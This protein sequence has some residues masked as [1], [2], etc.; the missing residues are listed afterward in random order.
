MRNLMTILPKRSGR[1]A[2]GSITVRHQGGR[3]KRFLREIDFARNKREV[4]GIVEDIQYD[5]NRNANIALILYE[6]GERRY[7]LAPFGLKVGQRI[8]TSETAAIEVANALPLGK[9]PV[10]TQVHNIEIKPGM[11]GQMVRGAGSSA[12]IQGKE[13]L[14]VL[15][16]LPSGEIRRFD[17]MAYATIGQVGNLEHRSRRL[18]K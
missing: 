13:D 2:S 1:G 6:D 8:V 17:P 4:K 14:W 11:G 9:I 15:V 5:P 16:K 12:V 3:A 7:I 18:G 10:G